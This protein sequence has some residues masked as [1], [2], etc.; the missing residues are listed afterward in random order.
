MKTISVIYCLL[1]A[2][3][4]EGAEIYAEGVEG[5]EVSFR[6]SHRLAWKN[7]KYLCRDTCGSEDKI[8]TVQSGRRVE[9]GRITLVDSGDGVFTVTFSQLRLSDSGIYWC[10]VDRPGLD[11]FTEVQLTVE[12]AHYTAVANLTTTV[13]PELEPDLS[14]TWTFEN[15]SNSTQPTSGMDTS[16]HVNL[17]IESNIP[18]NL[19]ASN[20]TN[21]GE[22][23]NSTGPV[24]YATFGA[25]A[26]VL[27]V[28]LLAVIIRKR[29]ENSKPQQQVCS[30]STELVS[31]DERESDCDY[32][33]IGEEVQS[34]KQQPGRLSRSHH[35]KQDPPTAA[36]TAAE[37]S[38]PFHIYE[39][40]S[41]GTTHSGHSA[42]NA[43]HEQN[44]MSGI[45]IKPLPP[46]RAGDGCD[47]T[48]K[49]TE[50]ERPRSR[51]FGLDLSGTVGEHFSLFE[52]TTQGS[53]RYTQF[54]CGISSACFSLISVNTTAVTGI[55]GQRFDFR[56]EYRN[57]LK[58]YPKYLW[59]EDT[60]YKLL[61]WTEKHDQWEKNG[62][63]SLYDNTTGA[64]FI[65]RVEKLTSADSGMY[66]CMVHISMS[67]DE[68]SFIQL[69]V[70]QAL[71]QPPQPDLCS[72]L[73]S[74]HR[75]STVTLGLGEYVDVD[76]PKHT[77][78]YEHLDI[79]QLEE[80]VYHNLNGSKDPKDQPLEV[81]QQI[82]KAKEKL[83]RRTN[84]MKM[85]FLLLVLLLEG[86]WETE[87][88][89]VTGVS[90][91]EVT[92]KCSHSYAFTNVKYFCKGDCKDKDI[93]IRTRKNG[94]YS[95]K[96]E[97]NT[98]YVTISHL[99]ID[100]SG[101][102]WCGIERVGVD[103]YNEVILTVIE[104]EPDSEIPSYSN[105][106]ST[107]KVVYI[108]AGLGVVLLALAMVLLIYFRYQKRHIN[109]SSG[110]DH[111]TVYATPP[112]QKQDGRHVTTSSSTASEDQET[113]SRTKNNF[114]L[115]EVQHRD[116]SRD[117]SD[118]IYSNVTA[119]SESHIQ[120]DGLFYS[121]VSFNKHTDSSTV[122]ACT[123]P[124]TYSIIKPK[125]TGESI[126]YD[127]IRTQF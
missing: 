48:N 97:G 37:C 54:H 124:L 59:Y 88:V 110:K 92:I 74:K 85:I 120:P 70:T 41:S 72:H 67:P 4:I 119:S 87:A 68:S 102:Y 56:C 63:F 22:Q 105:G 116:T 28:L 20:S 40:I 104:K 91:K 66:R 89:S 76:V 73:T 82:K 12:K 64:F 117:H 39:N 90:G 7:N 118:N 16:R 23:N 6:C 65:V 122:A 101:T 83:Q 95:I 62:R 19:T 14:S 77:C 53:Q 61:I 25:A 125:E 42:A 15:F 108:V 96:D 29:R 33:D 78:P 84:R 31:A 111:K 112:R 49:P 103:T 107:K 60:P 9:S 94:R 127:S 55:E 45:Y 79:S 21:G 30:N 18:S 86:L 126:V 43:Q 52:S 123:A 34:I 69:N 17:S 50:E 106:L 109:S 47:S 35:P 27:T 71:P 3:R 44:I 75:E 57:N 98:F 80:H 10:A 113:A 5:G 11:T 38:V 99:T 51:W 121:T 32:D 26:A 8:V 100:D 36:S 1:Y 13:I 81:K 58:S 2:A 114:S 46:L 115:S 24:L 93:L